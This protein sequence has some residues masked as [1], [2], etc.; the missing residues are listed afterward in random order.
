[1][2]NIFPEFI[3][4]LPK[5]DIKIDGCEA[6]LI[7]GETQQIIFAYVKN[8]TILAKHKHDSQW[9][10]VLEGKVDL[11]V[12]NKEKKCYCKGDSFYIPPNV[13]HSAFIYAGYS[14]IIIFNQKDRYRTLQ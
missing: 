11:I 5:A 2:N 1:M 6:Y 10:I 3:K 12:N 9:E 14:S 4:I 8:D 7:Q 13:Y